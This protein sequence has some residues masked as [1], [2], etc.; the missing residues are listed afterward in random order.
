MCC[1]GTYEET[2]VQH[3]STPV[4]LEI[5]QKKKQPLPLERLVSPNNIIFLSKSLADFQ[6]RLFSSCRQLQNKAF[7]S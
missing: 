6:V 2:E 3:G 4:Q 7:F 1:G 5:V